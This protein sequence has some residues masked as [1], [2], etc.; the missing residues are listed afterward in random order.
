METDSVQHLSHIRARPGLSVEVRQR[1]DQDFQSMS[2][3][4]FP[5][6]PFRNAEAVGSNPITSTIHPVVKRPTAR[7]TW[8]SAVSRVVPPAP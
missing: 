4:S 8:R 5:S 1:P 3:R 7:T 2:V 6:R